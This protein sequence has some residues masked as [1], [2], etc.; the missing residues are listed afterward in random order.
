MTDE[1]PQSAEVARFTLA[2][3]DM[4]QVSEAARLIAEHD[5]DLALA[6]RIRAVGLDAAVAE[7]QATPRATALGDFSLRVILETGL[8]VTYARPFTQGYG[9]GFP[10]P[11]EQFVPTEQRGLHDHLLKL[12]NQVYGHIDA[13]PPEG[14][15]RRASWNVTPGVETEVWRRARLLTRAELRDMAVLADN[16]NGRLRI[17]RSEDRSG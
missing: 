16:I 14:F 2:I 5:P 4:Q 1:S 17:A 9:S 11:V 13:N 12:R 10:L 3:D 8:I 6:E 15:R 7:A